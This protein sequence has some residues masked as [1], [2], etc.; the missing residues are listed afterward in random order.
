VVVGVVVVAV[1]QADVSKRIAISI[2]AASL[3]LASFIKVSSLI[4]WYSY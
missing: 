3:N 2:I 1:L 4:V